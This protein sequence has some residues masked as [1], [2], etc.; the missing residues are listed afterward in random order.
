[1]KFR[2]LL[3]S[4]LIASTPILAQTAPEPKSLPANKNGMIKVG[5]GEL[6][7]EM[8]GNGPTVVL[9]HAGLLD[10]RMWDGQFESLAK[11]FT[12]VRYDARGHGKSSVPDGPFAHFKDLQL[13][14]N[15]L[16][17][18]KATLVGLS[19]GARTALDFALA[20][21]DMVEAIV[22]VSPGASGVDFKDAV[23]L[24]DMKGSQE[25]IKKQDWDGFI[26]FFQRAWTD[27]PKRQ[28][29]DVDPAVRERVRVMAR[30]NLEKGRS[31]K[32]RIAELGAFP[33]L[34]EL[35]VP[36]LVIVGQLDSSDIHAVADALVEKANAKKVVVEGAGHMVNLEKPKEFDRL[37]AEYLANLPSRS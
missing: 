30:E 22:A 33:R 2:T 3:F 10:S 1:M 20:Y 25:A 36:I 13:L 24:E 19:L 37:V 4:L 29:S 11:K 8:A 32:G 12:V 14:L 35:K 26:E 34:A 6:Y 28:P 17:I 7:Y 18:K 31:A 21:P 23:I 27:G 16:G 5:T 15:G 9:L